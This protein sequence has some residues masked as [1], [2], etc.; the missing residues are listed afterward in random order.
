MKIILA[1][2]GLMG[3]GKSTAANH[4]VKYH[5]YQLVKFAGPLKAMTAAF[6]LD[7]EHIEGSL[8]EKPCSLLGGKT[9]RYFMQM[10]GTEFGRNLIDP[11]LWIRAWEHQVVQVPEGTPIVV[12]DC[13]FPNEAE[14]VHRMGTRPLICRITRA[15]NP[16]VQ[17]HA[18]ELQTFMPDCS[19]D[20]D[21]SLEQLYR[22]VDRIAKRQRRNLVGHHD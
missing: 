21:G 8:K 2:T 1:F 19:L 7:K 17:A 20:N 5:G 12:D 15:G 18:S 6:G 9:P 13:R 16:I 4:L 14:A 3:S 11:D 10:L 22:K